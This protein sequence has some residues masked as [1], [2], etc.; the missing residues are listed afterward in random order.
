[1]PDLSPAA[2]AVLDAMGR[3]YDHEPTRRLIAAD[4]LRALAEHRQGPITLGQRMDYWSPDD[5]TRR[6]LRNY[7]TELEGGDG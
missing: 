6:E 7:A 5:H 1:M 4:I 2:Q 3:S